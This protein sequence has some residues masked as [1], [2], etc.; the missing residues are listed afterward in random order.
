MFA[1]PHR[2]LDTLTPAERDAEVAG[3]VAA[4]TVRAVRIARGRASAPLNSEVSAALS[5]ELPQ[6]AALS[7]PAP[8]PGLGL[9]AGAER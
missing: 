5:L 7:V 3:I 8:D 9:R 2:H 6:H 4:A 1:H